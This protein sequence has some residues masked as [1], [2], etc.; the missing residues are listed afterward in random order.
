MI[1]I[2]VDLLWLRPEKVGGTESYIRNLLKAF[3]EFPTDELSFHLFVSMD[4]HFTFSNFKTF[5]NFEIT[6]VNIK[7][8]NVKIRLLFQNTVFPKIIHNSNID[9]FFEPVYSLPLRK[10]NI[11]SVVT[12]HDLQ[13]YHFPEYFSCY[14]RAWLNMAWKNSVRNARKIVAIS[15]FVKQDIIS[16]LHVN[17]DQIEVI[18]NPIYLDPDIS[19][20]RLMQKKWGIDPKQYFYTVSSLLPHKNT[21]VII[22]LLSLVKSQN[23]T[24]F[25][26]KLVIS[27]IKTNTPELETLLD[28]LNLQN[29]VIFTGYISDK[30]RNL[31]YKNA[32]LFLFPSLF[33]G[34]G[35]P[36]IESLMSGTKVITTKSSSIPEVTQ[37]MA[38]YVERPQDPLSWI[39]A[40]YQ[41]IDNNEILSFDSTS[42]Q[43]ENVAKKYYNLFLSTIGRK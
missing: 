25:P 41:A 26:S 27:G 30:E 14:K 29:D 40:I 42:Y 7:S 32:Y 22:E 11:P 2:G 28:K 9:L 8:S 12:I 18:Y 16:K 38:V 37:G 24:T 39:N 19:D 35:M 43:S 6:P 1:K 10:I 4:N 21:K 31:L 5:K 23:L 20:F 33:E 34:F 36:P 15:E 13:A 3:H 17:K